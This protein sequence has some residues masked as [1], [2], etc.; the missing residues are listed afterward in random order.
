MCIGNLPYMERD[1]KLWVIGNITELKCRTFPQNHGLV[2]G[3]LTFK[4]W[5]CVKKYHWLNIR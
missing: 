4:R 1:K 5:S 3:P 2:D